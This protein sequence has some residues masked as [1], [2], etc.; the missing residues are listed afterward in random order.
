MKL[1]N[2]INCVLLLKHVF[3]I[4]VKKLHHYCFKTLRINFRN[5]RN[6]TS[7]VLADS[8]STMLSKCLQLYLKYLKQDFIT[9]TKLPRIAGKHCSYRIGSSV[10][11][12]IIPTFEDTPWTYLPPT[13]QNWQKQRKEVTT[14]SEDKHERWLL[15]TEKK[16]YA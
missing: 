13:Y 9:N 1:R 16:K 15:A 10:S 7:P 12:K 5:K 14:C 8:Q 3:H 6:L 2:I 4:S 11:A